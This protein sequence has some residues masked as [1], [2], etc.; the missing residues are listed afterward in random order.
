[1]LGALSKAT[2]V[3]SVESITK[4]ISEYFTSPALAKA[5]SEAALKS[6]NEVRLC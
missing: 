2:N 5:N 1:M 6:F 4:A 3:V